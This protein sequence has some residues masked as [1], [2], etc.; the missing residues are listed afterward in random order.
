MAGHTRESCSTECANFRYF[1]L[2]DYV[3]HAQSSACFCGNEYGRYRTFNDAECDSQTVD[4]GATG[5]GSPYRNAVYDLAKDTCVD[6]GDG[7]SQPDT[8]H[9]HT[10]C[11]E[12][13]CTCTNGVAAVG[14]ACPKNGAPS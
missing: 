9:Y 6:C 3:S 8:N 14:A 1:A 10:T 5:V 12:N 11:Q 7:Y 13:E 4:D 2:Q